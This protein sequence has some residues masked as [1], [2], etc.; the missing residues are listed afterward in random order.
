M[1]PA[2]QCLPSGTRCSRAIVRPSGRWR[3]SP[4]AE[5]S[6]DR[7]PSATGRVG[8]Y[9]IQGGDSRGEDVVQ[10]NRRRVEVKRCGKCAVETDGV[11]LERACDHPCTEIACA[12]ADLDEAAARRPRP[13]FLRVREMRLGKE[14]LPHATILRQ[15]VP[16]C[17]R[18]PPERPLVETR[19]LE[20]LQPG[21]RR[22]GDSP[23]RVSAY[24]RMLRPGF[25]AGD[26]FRVLR[27]ACLVPSTF[28]MAVAR[29]TFEAYAG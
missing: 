3:L 16:L 23:S 25:V 9:E 6:G 4:A 27:I 1:T 11:V 29:M 7:R 20:H 13:R 2:I 22:T 12:E 24:L 28:F 15:R 21:R 19:E 10:G 14:G 8:P 17:I 5:V 18:A 26:G